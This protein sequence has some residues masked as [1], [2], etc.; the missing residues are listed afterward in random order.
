MAIVSPSWAAPG[1]FPAVHEI[2]LRVFRENFGL[3]VVEFPTTRQV[4]ASAK[5]RARD[6][7]AAFSDP[8][9]RA[10]M[11]SIGGSDQI[12]VLP[13]LDAQVFI[14]NPK[15][16]FG[17]SDNTNMLNWL[18]RLGISG[19][20]GG[21]TLVHLARPGGAHPVFIESLRR[22]LFTSETI[23]IEPVER[24]TDLQCNWDD[25]S[26]LEEPLPTTQESGWTWHNDNRVVTGPTWAATLK[27]F[28]GILQR[29]DGSCPMRNTREVY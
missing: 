17:Y 4:G 1:V 16:F 3:E 15:P 28:T 10:V 21:S 24:F 25:L 5:E 29:I 14:D 13:Y 22:A 20:H 2:G 23:E 8:S 9:I 6:L 19:Y 26:T 12:T 18:W 7:M 27:Y 11:A